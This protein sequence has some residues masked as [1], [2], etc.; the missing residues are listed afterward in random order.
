[1]VQER[2]NSALTR[3]GANRTVGQ[4]WRQSQEVTGPQMWVLGAKQEGGQAQGADSE[5]RPTCWMHLTELEPGEVSEPLALG[6]K[7]MDVKNLS[8]TDK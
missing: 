4:C 8:N 3:I 5:G 6:A 1:M 2:N 7:F